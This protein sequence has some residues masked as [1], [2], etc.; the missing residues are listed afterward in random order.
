MARRA[1]GVGQVVEGV[2]AR[3]TNG[4]RIRTSETVV[5]EA[6]GYGMFEIT[7]G[8]KGNA[9]SLEQIHWGAAG[10]ARRGIV[11]DEGATAGTADSMGHVIWGVKGDQDGSGLQ[12]D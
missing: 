7:F 4:S 3:V 8:A 6:V 10:G 12:A 11:C 2:G 1:D 9:R 5:T